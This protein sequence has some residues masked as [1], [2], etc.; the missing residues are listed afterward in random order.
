[1][2]RFGIFNLSSNSQIIFQR[3]SLLCAPKRSLYL[4]LK[5]KKIVSPL[6]GSLLDVLAINLIPLDTK[7]AL[8]K[9][10]QFSSLDL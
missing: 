8:A 3:L 7:F 2:L 9:E 5:S 4:F 1:M 10:P 6:E